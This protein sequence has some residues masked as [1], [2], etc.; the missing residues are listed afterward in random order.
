MFSVKSNEEDVE[1][2]CWRASGDMNYSMNS[3]PEGDPIT[4]SVV[5]N[6]K[7]PMGHQMRL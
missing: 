6:E 1:Y 2:Q 7:C 4:C 5:G 3:C